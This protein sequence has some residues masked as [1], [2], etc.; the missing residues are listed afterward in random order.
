VRTAYLGTSS[1][2]ATV[3]RRLAASPHRPQLVITPP[4]RPKGR[5]RRVL[6]PPA[7]ETA[8]ELGIDLFQ[9]ESVNDEAALAR[10]REARPEAAAV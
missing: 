3:L 6:P 8:R 7:A 1:F 5:G 9:A 4:D 10:L 2:A